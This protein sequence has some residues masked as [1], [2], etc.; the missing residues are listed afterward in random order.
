MAETYKAFRVEK[1]GDTFVRSVKT[2]DLDALPPGEVMVRVA[3]SALNYKDALSATGHPGVTTKFPNTPGIDAAGTVV[4]SEHPH[5]KSGDEVIVTSYDLGMNTPGGFGGMIRVPAGW[6]VP[7]PKGLSLRES[8]IL[9]TAGLT[10]GLCV[11]SFIQFGIKPETGPALVTGASGGVGS[12]AVALLAKLGFEVVASTGSAGSHDLLGRLGASGI[13]DRA[14]LAEP[15]KRPML[16][17]RFGCAIDN[18]GGK[19]LEN[20]IKSMNHNGALALVGLV[21]S[22]QFATSVLPFIL[23]GVALFGIDSAECPLS[24]RKKVW[25]N[26]A[27]PWKPEALESCEDLVQEIGLDGLDDAVDA[28]LKGRTQ[29][30][31]VVNL[32]K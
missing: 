13:M 9:G 16:S 30:R 7:L 5:F 3:Y 14:E 25:E 18:V 31:I 12:L 17:G 19:T 29:G 2:V 23:R 8:M 20:V 15:N 4:S 11:D 28:I 1:E 27:G 32:Q 26:L 21:E 10:A 24:R 6:V 22:P